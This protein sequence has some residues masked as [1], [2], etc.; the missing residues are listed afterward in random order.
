MQTERNVRQQVAFRVGLPRRRRYWPCIVWFFCFRVRCRLNPPPHHY[1]KWPI[2]L[3]AMVSL[4]FW[5]R[6][7]KQ[8]A[9]SFASWRE[10]TAKPASNASRQNHTAPHLKMNARTQLLTTDYTSEI[11]VF[12]FLVVVYVNGCLPTWSPWYRASGDSGQSMG[13]IA[14]GGSRT[15]SQEGCS[16][17]SLSEMLD[18]HGH[19]NGCGCYHTTVLCDSRSHFFSKS[20]EHSVW[21]SSE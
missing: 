19:H 18:G 2:S 9:G 11:I 16:H 4:N 1:R 6:P 3:G 21:I 5:L 10:R 12:V 8:I 7:N 20:L 14:G 13:R 17:A 15:F